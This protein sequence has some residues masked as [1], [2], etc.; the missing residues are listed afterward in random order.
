MIHELKKILAYLFFLLKFISKQKKEIRQCVPLQI[1]LVGA[2]GFE[3]AT[4]WSQTTRS[5]QTEP[6]PDIFLIR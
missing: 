6:C 2:T 3:P 1:K 5:S 4:S